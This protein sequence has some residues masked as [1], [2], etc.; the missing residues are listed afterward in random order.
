LITNFFLFNFTKDLKNVSR[1]VTLPP[2]QRALNEFAAYLEFIKV[3]PLTVKN[4]LSD[5]NQFLKWVEKNGKKEL[6]EITSKDIKRYLIIEFA[7]APEATK[8]RK[9]DFS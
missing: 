5:I 8:E 3:S 2:F 9:T 4:Y 6:T 1:A 7:A